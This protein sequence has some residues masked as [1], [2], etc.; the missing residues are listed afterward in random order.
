MQ[1]VLDKVTVVIG[2]NSSTR[3]FRVIATGIDCLANM[4]TLSLKNSNLR[5]DITGIIAE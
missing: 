3:N 5:H 1:L 2:K 4:S